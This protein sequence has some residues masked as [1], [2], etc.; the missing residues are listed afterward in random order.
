V[1]ILVLAHKPAVVG[2]VAVQQLWVE[3]P[4]QFLANVV[5]HVEVLSAEMAEA[6]E[7]TLLIVGLAVPVEVLAVILGV[8]AG[9]VMEAAVQALV[10]VV[11][12][13][14]PTTHLHTA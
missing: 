14:C 7:V 6:A 5:Q 3:E 2:L 4:V 10:E 1:K 12:L 11:V 9:L 13:V 8:G